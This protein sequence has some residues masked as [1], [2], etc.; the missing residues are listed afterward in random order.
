MYRG[1][2]FLLTIAVACFACT[3]E[4]PADRPDKPVVVA[5]D[6]PPTEGW[7]CAAPVDC[8]FG[9]GCA[10]GFCGA[11]DSA[12][13]CRATEACRDDRSCGVC[14]V[15][16]ECRDGE[17]CEDG[18]C[19]AE[20]PDTWN[21]VVDEA[22]WDLI[23]MDPWDEV[24]VP[25]RLETGDAVYGPADLRLYGGSS[26]TR[27]KSSFRVRFPEDADHPGFARK[28]NLRA[29]YNDPSFLRTWLGYETF[30]RLT[31]TPVPRARF[32]D[33]EIN[34]EPW[35]L[36][37]EVERLGGKFL[38]VNGR[39]RDQ[40]MYEAQQDWPSGALTDLPDDDAWRYVWSKKTGDPYDFSDIQSLVRDV[41]GADLADSWGD[42]T[43]TTWR[44]ELA[45]D[46][47]S[48]VDYLAVMALIQNNDHVT[49]N[50]YLSLQAPYGGDPRWEVYPFDLDLSFGCSWTEEHG[51][52]CEDVRHDA[53]WMN[54]VIVDPGADYCW[55][56]AG[57]H[58]ALLN[59]ALYQRYRQRI[60][61]FTESAWWTE[62]GP[63]LASAMAARVEASVAAD[64]MD[65]HETLEE[66]D[67]ALAELEG[68][69]DQRAAFLRNAL[70]CPVDAE[71]AP[72]GP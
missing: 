51:T 32:V 38:E 68:F 37:L 13:D 23:Q 59:D 71:I 35:G 8:D 39:D 27:P 24:Y 4:Q 17:V 45:M 62:E 67:A 7:T 2:V 42:E 58:L 3:P 63:A 30:R 55:C 12:L 31:R 29:E 53:W 56:N 49:N 41:I 9:M 36:M 33:V 11:C 57:I 18:Y 69:F 21:I 20:S 66:W 5:D 26:R 61:S 43:T 19:L 54:G 46:L 28:I 65:V 40:P 34:G 6:P 47:D 44:T 52:M 1:R 64:P 14:S 60:C 22:D 72:P 15:D 25:V 50:F 48:Y 16:S 10:D 70:L